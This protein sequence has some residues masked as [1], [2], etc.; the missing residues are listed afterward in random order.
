[1]NT[2]SILNSNNQ[3]HLIDVDTHE[4]IKDLQIVVNATDRLSSQRPILTYIHG[5]IDGNLIYLIATNSHRLVLVKL[6]TWVPK[7]LNNKDFLINAKFAKKLIKD[8]SK[9]GQ[10]LLL[11]IVDNGLKVVTTIDNE[12]QTYIDNVK[13]DPRQYPGIKGMLPDS[14]MI[15]TSFNI[16]R[17]DIFK[18]IQ[19]LTKV[20]K[21]DKNYVVKLVVNNDKVVI[22]YNDTSYILNAFNINN[23]NSFT[24]CFNPIELKKCLQHVSQ[25]ELLSFNFSGSLSPFMIKGVRNPTI[26]IAPVRVF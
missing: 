2:Q 1:M 9:L 24:V 25:R 12:L 23:D 22:S 20:C 8:K 13:I 6:S 14:S 10:D 17:K 16:R 4:F 3:K 5:K 7:E 11:S 18:Q 15:K 19:S 26:L 21:N